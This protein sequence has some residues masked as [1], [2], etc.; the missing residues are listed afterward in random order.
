MT[1]RILYLIRHG[2][3]DF[4]WVGDPW[5]SARGEQWDP[6]LSDEGESRRASSRDGSA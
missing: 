6:P 3:S 1:G 4:E 2:Q 5:A